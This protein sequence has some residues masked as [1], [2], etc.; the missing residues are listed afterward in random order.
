MQRD[1]EAQFCTVGCVQPPTR[2][3]AEK[4]KKLLANCYFPS[5]WLKQ[6]N[7]EK[8]V[9]SQCAT[10]APGL[11]EDPVFMFRSVSAA[12]K[13]HFKMREVERQGWEEEIIHTVAVHS[14]PR[15]TGT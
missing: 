14:N 7:N 4:Y 15:G 9:G 2:I 3:D 12:A 10:A 6:N 13:L 1:T 5:K 8:G 11:G